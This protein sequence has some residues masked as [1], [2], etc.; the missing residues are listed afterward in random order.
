[1]VMGC[2]GEVVN[3]AVAVEAPRSNFHI[4]PFRSPAYTLSTLPS[5]LVSMATGVDKPFGLAA[6][7][8]VPA[9]MA[10][11]SAPVLALMM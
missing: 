11:I 8:V 1:M 4:V 7:P 6:L 5:L 2:A 9:L 3:K 10:E